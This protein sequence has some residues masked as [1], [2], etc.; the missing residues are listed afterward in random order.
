MYQSLADIPKPF[1]EMMF[2]F[3][4][5]RRL[6]FTPDEIK[7]WWRPDL[8]GVGVTIEAQGKSLGFKMEDEVM[9]SSQDDFVVKWVEA[10]EAALGFMRSHPDDYHQMFENSRVKRKAG[11][12]VSSVVLHGFKIKRSDKFVD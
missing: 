6:G 1:M 9:F 12:F 8:R 11:A 3:E 4:G 10:S 7:F 5:F 2:F